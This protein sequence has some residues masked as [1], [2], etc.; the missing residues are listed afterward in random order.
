[1]SKAAKVKMLDLLAGAGYS[2][3]KSTK[4][5]GY[6]FCKSITVLKFF[7]FVPPAPTSGLFFFSF[8]LIKREEENL[9]LE[10]NQ[11]EKVD[12][13]PGLTTAY[14]SIPVELLIGYGKSKINSK[15]IS[16]NDVIPPAPGWPV[17]K[18][19]QIQN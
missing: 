4:A 6:P 10:L 11:V 18:F 12:F 13:L 19:M 7:P 2:I 14:F 17:P 1:M 9:N 15:Y 8:R 16:F 3:T 5:C